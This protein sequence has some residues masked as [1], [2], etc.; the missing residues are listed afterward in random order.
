MA[1][2]YGQRTPLGR[3]YPVYMVR[4]ASPMNAKFSVASSA[5]AAH[6][7]PNVGRANA[8]LRAPSHC[9]WLAPR[10]RLRRSS[11][12]ASPPMRAAQSAPTSRRTTSSAFTTR[13]RCAQSGTQPLTS[14]APLP[15]GIQPWPRRRS[16]HTNP[17]RAVRS[18][19]I[20]FNEMNAER[21]KK[22]KAHEPVPELINDQIEKGKLKVPWTTAK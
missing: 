6:V 2:G 4:A 8:A 17:S 16:R 21:A 14:A 19:T 7:P 18:Q 11:R 10:P 15:A 13:R 9:G 5:A 20:R 12:S 22:V 3:C 1:S